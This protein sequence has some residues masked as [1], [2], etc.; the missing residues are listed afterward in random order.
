MRAFYASRIGEHRAKTPEG[1]LIAT[2]IPIARTG[3]QEYRS[4]EIDGGGDEVVRVYRAP[5]E[6]FSPATIASFEGK[7]VTTPHPPTFLTPE[8]DAAYSKGHVQNVRKG[9]TLED[10]EQVLLADIVVKDATLIDLIDNHTR[11][12][13]SCGYACEWVPIDDEY[14]PSKAYAQRQIRGN[15][16]AVV[17]NGR[18]GEAVRIL[19]HAA[20]QRKE[21][22]SMLEK[23][24]VAMGWKPPATAAVMDSE[25]E[26]VKK[27]EEV[28]SKAE[29]R[30]E[31]RNTDEKEEKKEEKAEAKDKK[32]AKD[33]DKEEGHE[34]AE[35]KEIKKIAD[36]MGVFTD[37][38]KRF[39]DAVSKL[40]KIQKAADD[41][42]DKKV[43]DDDDE[44]SE[45][46]KKVEG[47][48]EKEAA[49][50]SELIPVETLP[51]EDRPKNVIPGAKDN[52]VALDALRAVR[53]VVAASGDRKA[54]D[55]WNKAFRQLKGE[56]GSSKKSYGKIA[57]RK[58]PS[59]VE[60][61]E[62]R[63]HGIAVDRQKE[64]E[65]FEAQAAKFHRKNPNEVVV[66]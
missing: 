48:E 44:E 18:A 65:T 10:G 37:A 40:G 28:N 16:V 58:K 64:S 45:K 7:S 49:D 14:T 13:L 17:S 43:H 50:D 15:H 66:Q 52:S 55:S 26:A 29:E 4:S 5:E 35:N 38:V 3:W 21:E 56:T 46:E 34:E 33:D 42:D 63:L 12:E 2:S 1:Y 23:V 41:D 8:N 51:K 57:D 9:D 53:E 19:D 20:V 54:M 27:N 30:A 60:E 59:E 6:V 36:A 31:M 22:P 62:S 25:S 32:H 24:L 39:T 47:E 11:E 61:A